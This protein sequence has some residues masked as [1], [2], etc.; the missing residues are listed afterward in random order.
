MELTKSYSNSA[1]SIGQWSED[2]TSML[3][4]LF[5]KQRRIFRSQ[6]CSEIR[7]STPYLDIIEPEVVTSCCQIPEAVYEVKQ[8]QEITCCEETQQNDSV[9]SLFQESHFRQK[10]RVERKI[11]R[12]MVNHSSGSY[13]TQKLKQNTILGENKTL[14]YYRNFVPV[15]SRDLEKDGPDI[16]QQIDGKLGDDAIA[17]EETTD[18]EEEESC[19]LNRNLTFPY[20]DS[21]NPE[22]QSRRLFYWLTCTYR[23]TPNE[24][25][26]HVIVRQTGTLPKLRGKLW[27]KVYM[28][29]A[30]KAHRITLAES[31]SDHSF[32]S[33]EL[34]I[35][36]KNKTAIHEKVLV[37][38]LFDQ[39]HV[40]ARTCLGDWRLQLIGCSQGPKIE[41]EKFLSGQL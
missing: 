2:D 13:N 23:L 40:F 36:I 28:E 18:D 35:Q 16:L 24:D 29:E 15:F 41:C 27:A 20:G 22:K 19:I 6:I 9:K 21:E 12:Q 7:D 26:L 33:H 8:Q 39:K 3:G 17:F 14:S 37:I 1:P 25:N 11:I 30:G 38:K 31:Q 34:F 32:R 10:L 4:S 5:P